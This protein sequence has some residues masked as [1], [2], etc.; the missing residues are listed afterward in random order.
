MEGEKTIRGCALRIMRPEAVN[1]PGCGYEVEFFPDEEKRD[2]PQ[3]GQEI[4]RQKSFY[5]EV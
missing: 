1:C 4:K 5:K 3:C 2:C